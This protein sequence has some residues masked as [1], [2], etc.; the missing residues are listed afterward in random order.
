MICCENC[1]NDLEAKAII[2]GTV[3]VK[4]DCG[5][6]EST[7][8]Y[9]YDT[10]KNDDLENSFNY[11]LEIY[12]P[13]DSLPETF[14]KQYLTTLEFELKHKWGIFANAKEKGLELIK[15]ICPEKF[16]ETP[17]LFNGDIGIYNLNEEDYLRNNS[18]LQIYYW[19]DF[20]NEIKKVNR[21]HSNIMNVQIL[22]E[23]CR[24]S[25]INL[26]E[27]MLFYRARISEKNGYEK[28]DM[29]APPMHKVKDGRANPIGI[30]CLY[31]S[32]NEKTTLHEIRA[33]AFDYVTMGEFQALNNISVVDF[34]M[35][36]QTSPL[37]VDDIKRYAVNKSHLKDISSEIARPLRSTDGP[38]DYLPSQYIIDFIKNRG[39]QGVKYK[40]TVS[41]SGFNL[42][43]FDEKLFD[44]IDTK[45]YMIENIDY[46]YSK[47]EKR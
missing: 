6:C 40:S 46:K 38:L 33:G 27:D 16:K 4:G 1:F 41:D 15:A 34:T 10:D 24:H 32:N 45:I 7:N 23:F 44:C 2:S 12:T 19:P 39:Y 35:L 18:L 11:L 28:T 9:I 26:K 30:P 29:G 20:V 42:A 43:V 13:L 14:P 17:R 37:M 36:D 31:L 5:V 22:A 21:F 47:V 3:K 8:V 25:E